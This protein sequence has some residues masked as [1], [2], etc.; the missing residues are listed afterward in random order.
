M[1]ITFDKAQH[2]YTVNGEIASI[3]VTQLLRKHKLAPSYNGVSE[4]V[5]NAAA[6]RG[7]DI[8]K[9]LECLIKYADY[10]P[11]TTEGE[12]F[13][14]YID[15]FIDSACAE[16]LL[17]YKYKSMWLCGTADII[18]FFKKSE[19]GC[20]VADHKTT[21]TINREYV[22]WQV[23][24]LDYML[25]QLKEPINGNVIKWKGANEFLCFH[26]TKDGE[27]EVIK[28]NKIPDEEIE[29]LLEAEYNGEIYER[30]ELVV[31]SDI[32]LGL[33]NLTLAI[34]TM[35]ERLA[36]M[37]EQ[38]Q[39]YRDI[40]KDAM[41]KQGIKS[42]ENDKVK[43]TYVCP[44]D[45]LSVDSAKLKKEYPQIWGECQKLTKVK[46]SLKITIKGKIDE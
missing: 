33:T 14:K 43:I 6:E 39:K 16:Q 40:L 1:E 22:S 11:M 17:A 13:K 3:S 41:E 7:T 9:D 34:D 15:E 19:K 42:F 12:S 27:M 36:K 18:G 26:Y 45:R 10:S 30:K 28:L 24:I 21:S 23:S 29:R 4:S 32:S 8:H 31:D 44:Q 25:R 46:S 35:E 37:K 20:F 38:Q 5:L 2:C